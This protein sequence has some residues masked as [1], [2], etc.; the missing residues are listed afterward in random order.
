MKMNSFLCV[1]AFTSLTSMACSNGA[2]FSA[3]SSV[4]SKDR[5]AS[6]DG[7]LGNGSTVPE[8]GDFGDDS[9]SGSSANGTN[10]NENNPSGSNSDGTNPNGTGS[11]P[12]GS[13][14]NPNGTGTNPNGS[15]SNPNGSGSNSTEGNNP[16]SADDSNSDDYPASSTN[17]PNN[18]VWNDV[19]NQCIPGT[20]S[21][22]PG[23]SGTGYNPNQNGSQNQNKA[24]S[25]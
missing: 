11:N 15:G 7:N 25:K 18:C 14:S 13:S 23:Q 2:T 20:Q 4:N 1:V 12:N 17:N 16:D 22:I 8:Q 24:G 3:G 9:T 19:T 21:Q 6:E 10:S 5:A